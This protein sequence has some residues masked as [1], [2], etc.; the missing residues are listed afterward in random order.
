MTGSPSLQRAQNST[1][2]QQHRS[3]FNAALSTAQPAL[4]P[5]ARLLEKYPKHTALLLQYHGEPRYPVCHFTCI[6]I[7][8]KVID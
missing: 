8:K 5:S 6:F 3:A 2:A 4:S 7:F 1:R